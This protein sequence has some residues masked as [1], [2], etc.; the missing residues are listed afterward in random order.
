[1]RALIGVIIMVGTFLLFSLIPE[2]DHTTE[3]CFS[4]ALPHLISSFLV[5]GVLPVGWVKLTGSDDELTHTLLEPDTSS[6]SSK[7]D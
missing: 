1:M 3:F 2:Q 4:Y 7:D 6:E 5:F